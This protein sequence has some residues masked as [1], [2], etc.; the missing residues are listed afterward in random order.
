[1]NDRFELV[2][3]ALLQM[4]EEKKYRTLRDVLITMNPADIASLFSNTENSKI[5][6]LLRVLP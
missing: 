1:M 6:L 2:I 4:L 3:T 5:P